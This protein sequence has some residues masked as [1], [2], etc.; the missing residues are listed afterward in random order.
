MTIGSL[1][2]ETDDDYLFDCFVHYPPVDIAMK[3]DSHGSIL[4]GR[5]GAGKTAIIRYIESRAEHSVQIR[6]SDMAMSYVS[7]SDAL[8]FLHAIGADLDLLFQVLWKHVLCI[9]FIRLRWAVT[10][11]EKSRSIFGRLTEKFSRDQRKEKALRYLREWE[12]EFWITMD[13]NIRTITERVE[14]KVEAELGSEIKKWKA[15]GQYDKQLSNDKKTDLVRRVKS[16]ISGEQLSQLSGVIDILSEFDAYEKGNQSKYYLLI[17]KLD[18]NWVDTSVRFRL[19]RALIET[20]KTFRRV[21]HL[22]VLVAMRSDILERVVQETKDISYQREKSE[23]Y[24]VK[25]KWNRFELRSLADSRILKMYRRQY[26]TQD[27]HFEDLFPYQ[28]G[29]VDPF[30]YI[31]ERTLMR[32]R[33]VI[34]FVNQCLRAADGTLEVTA[35]HIRGAEREYSRLRR[36]ALEHEWQS[37]FPT[38]K[39]LLDFVAEVRKESFQIVEMTVGPRLE[40]L[41]LNVAAEPKIDF[42]PTHAAATA[43]CENP[44]EKGLA[45]AKEVVSILY[46]VGAVGL[47]LD[48]ADR[49]R[50]SHLDEPIISVAVIPD[51]AKVRVHPM[52]HAALKINLVH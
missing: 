44:S 10:D 42:D 14:K 1:A 18:E 11:S 27:V 43:Y 32:P 49:F 3:V 30:D 28:V 8:S 37:A 45:F 4:T 24:F 6:P 15:R 36:E 33:D 26:T 22:K 20:V 25:I 47:K 48:P 13:E 34:A 16:I 35:T 46:R 17:D 51:E 5:T 7:N 31:I 50:Y 19:I 9:E 21:R 38:L 41:G 23:E 29:R 40:Q 2:A 52:L 39:Q 12:G